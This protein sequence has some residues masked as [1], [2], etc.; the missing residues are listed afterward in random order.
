ML[1]I[2]FL[3]IGKKHQ[4]SYKIVVVDKKRSP[5]SGKFTEQLGFYNPITK[6]KAV[7]KERVLYWLSQG[8]QPSDV[9]HNL[10]V[11]EGIIIGEKVAVHSKK[12]SKKKETKDAT[13]EEIKETKEAP[14]EEAPKEEA[15][16][17]KEAPVEKES[18]DVS[19]KKEPPVEEK[20]EKEAEKK[21]ESIEEEKIV[22]EKSKERK[23]RA[24]EPKKQKPTEE[25]KSTEKEDK[26][27]DKE[28]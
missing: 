1:S 10:L 4:P 25:E 12:P 16:E 5:K 15:K 9:V 21:D 26:D 8:A 13:E 24:K 22:E 17:T 7:N 19:A 14:K 27:I 23:T 18:T 2:R 20:K 11:K 3:R 28:K 6:E